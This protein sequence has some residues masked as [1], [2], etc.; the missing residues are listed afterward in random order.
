M[1]QAACAIAAMVPN[2]TDD[3]VGCRRSAYP[4]ILAGL[5]VSNNPQPNPDPLAATVN[6]IVTQ[7]LERGDTVVPLDVLVA[8]EM[9][10]EELIVGWRRGDLP[11]LE[12]GITKGL[13]RTAR[14]LRLV[15]DDAV[16][17][18]LKP[19]PGK[20]LRSG[21]GPRRPLRFSK[22]GDAASEAAYATHFVRA[23]PPVP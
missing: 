14:V 4:V 15:R 19:A 18:G 8:L 9:L 7:L 1:I 20:Y 23:K 21:K 13:A 17:R 12:R 10:D 6:Q 16:A 11:Y 2:T 3:Q 5:V 22:Q